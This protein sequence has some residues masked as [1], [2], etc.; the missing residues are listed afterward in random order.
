MKI[1][2]EI[3]QRFESALLRNAMPAPND[4][5]LYFRFASS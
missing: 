5:T 1:W 2:L 3:I 4:T